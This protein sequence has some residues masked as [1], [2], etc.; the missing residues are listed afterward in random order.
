MT[1]PPIHEAN[2]VTTEPQRR[3]LEEMSRQLS[4]RL[5]EMIDEQNTRARDFIEQQHSLSPLPEIQVPVLTKP[6]ATA[7]P[8]APKPV[9]SPP[10]AIPQQPA[11]RQCI[12]DAPPLP[13]EI[14]GTRDEKKT[15]GKGKSGGSN[16]WIFALVTFLLFILI[17][18]C[19]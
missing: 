4:Q 3:A 19:N 11:S 9:P 1:P 5:E 10:P 2:E 12:S 8:Y 14:P 18:S 7:R 15:A 6:R 16:G 13:F 17:R